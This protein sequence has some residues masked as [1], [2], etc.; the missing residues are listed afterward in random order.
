MPKTTSSEITRDTL[1]QR[2][3]ALRDF[4]ARFDRMA[5]QLE[6]IGAESMQT[7]SAESWPRSVKSLIAY[8]SAIQRT[9]DASLLTPNDK[10][11]AETDGQPL[12]LAESKRKYKKG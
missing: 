4:A 6:M 9:I 11:R 10:V 1:R 2:A 5:D 3:A 8:A 12:I 7:T